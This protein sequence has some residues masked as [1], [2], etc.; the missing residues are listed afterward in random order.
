MHVWLWWHALA[1]HRMA[2]A[3][4]LVWADL[5]KVN[6]F[7]ST[8]LIYTNSRTPEKAQIQVL[9]EEALPIL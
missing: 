3:S 6:L 1:E 5:I 7:L 9:E 8:L 2:T 4:D